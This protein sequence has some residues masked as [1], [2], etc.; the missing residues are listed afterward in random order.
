MNWGRCFFWLYEKFR[1]ADSAVLDIQMDSSQCNIH[2]TLDIQRELLVINRKMA[3][4][5]RS[6]LYLETRIN[7]QILQIFVECIVVN[8]HFSC[9]IENDSYIL[10]ATDYLCCF[11]HIA[12]KMSSRYSNNNNNKKQAAH[13]DVWTESM[14]PHKNVVP[15]RQVEWFWKFTKKHP[16][17]SVFF[18]VTSCS[19]P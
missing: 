4:I 14:P 9:G 1:F 2:V 19:K 12:N 3:T 18:H 16:N 6:P 7:P 5:R 10:T 17:I 11:H 8:N 15:H 13:D